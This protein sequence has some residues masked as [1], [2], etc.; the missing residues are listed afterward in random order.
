L[1]PALTLVIAALGI[2]ITPVAASAV[3]HQP[4]PGPGYITVQ[5]GR[6][7][8]GSFTGGVTACKP[9]PGIE[10]LQTIAADLQGRGMIGTSTVVVDRTNATTEKCYQNDVY[11]DWADLH[12]LNATYGWQVDSGGQTHD[13]MVTM[14]PAEQ[15]TESCDTLPTFSA[16]GFNDAWGLFGYGNNQS[17]PAIQSN[18]VEE[19]FAYGRLYGTQANYATAINNRDAM[20]PN[21]YQLTTNV[22]GGECNDPTMPCY[23]ISSVSN[24]THYESPVAL[25]ALAASEGSDQWLDLQFYRL[26]TGV[27]SNGNQDSWNCD[28]SLPW[29]DHWT[30]VVEGYC[31]VDFDEI[32]NAVPPGIVSADPATVA[33]AWG[34]APHAPPPPIATLA[35]STYLGGAGSDQ[36][37]M[38]AAAADGGVYAAADLGNGGGEGAV[39]EYSPTGSVDWDTTIG[40]TGEV[41]PYYIRADAAGVYVVGFTTVTALPGATNLDPVTGDTAFISVLSPTTGAVETSTYL[42]GKGFSAANVDAIDP[43]TGDVVVGSSTGTQTVI[44]RLNP[45]ATTVLWSTT[46]GGAAYSTHPYGMQTDSS[47]DI[48]VA[49]LTNSPIYP[50]VNA[51]Q[52]TYGGGMDTGIT[53]YSPT[54]AIRW[55]TYLGGSAEEHVNGLDIDPA[56]NVYVVGRTFSTNF[57]L[58]NAL[59]STNP[60]A[61]A[62]YVA[63]YSASGVLRYSTYI[64]GQNGA[65]YFGGVAVASDGTAWAVGGSDSTLLPTA[66]GGSAHVGGNDAYVAAIEPGGAGLAFAGYFGGSATDAGFGTVLTSAGLWVVGRTDSTNF[67]T[68]NPAQAANAGGYDALV[69]LFT[70]S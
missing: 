58:L 31:A 67:P 57:P 46:L 56:G 38:V 12:A 6:S 23:S 65:T 39:V 10:T 24:N 19:C 7:I 52:T 68:L 45:A 3:P 41:W 61:D 40:G 22:L 30:S 35:A 34:R 17:T 69:S 26:M 21:G 37:N 20:N 27:S 64:G 42:G 14:T 5:M 48:A 15:Q 2:A 11:A 36:S 63:E 44:Q 54:G 33:T 53:E 13:D 32:L 70:L 43:T 9:V 16:E 28:P 25:A 4:T 18:I 51:A 49:T 60:A 59:Y 62:A 55:S 47:G 8:E 1:K 50:V 29:T 66:G